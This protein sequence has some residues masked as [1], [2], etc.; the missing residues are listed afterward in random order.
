MTFANPAH[1]YPNYMGVTPPPREITALQNEDEV[2]CD[3][4][5]GGNWKEYYLQFVIG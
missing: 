4:W 3:I 2:S 1:P 5:K